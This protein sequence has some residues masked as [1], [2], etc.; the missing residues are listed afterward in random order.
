MLPFAHVGLTLGAAWLIKGDLARRQMKSA[1]PTEDR[2]K[3]K[4]KPPAK[5]AE[6]IDYRV[7][8]VC[9]LLPDIIDKPIGDFLFRNYFDEGR[10]FGHTLLF[11]IILT[12][13][14]IYLYKRRRKLWMLLLAFGT[15]TPLILDFMWLQPRTLLWPIYGLTFPREG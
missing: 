4:P 2:G 12:I 9:A 6:S 1:K 8:M 13:G 14:G 10:I 15:F 5:L 3:I 11:L 7:V